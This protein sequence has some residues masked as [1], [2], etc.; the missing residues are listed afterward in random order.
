MQLSRTAATDRDSRLAAMGRAVVRTIRSMLY[1]LK[2]GLIG[3]A[4]GSMAITGVSLASGVKQPVATVAAK[5]P[6]A[7]TLWPVQPASQDHLRR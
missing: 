7:D 1:E 5:A 4:I 6:S 2:F 3:F